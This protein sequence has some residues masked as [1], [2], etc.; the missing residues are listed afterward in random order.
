MTF[1]L[2]KLLENGG[3]WLE[4][5]QNSIL[6]AATIITVS[7][8]ISTIS[9]LLVTRILIATFFDTQAG[10]EALD[11]FWLAFQIP[12]M[13]FQLIILGALSA[14]FIP[15]FTSYKNK[16]QA[17]AFEM[18]SI[19][20]NILLLVFLLVG[21]LIFIFAGTLTH[22][23]TGANITPEQIRIIIN[24]TRLMIFAQ[25]F[26]AISNFMTGILQSF[27]RFIVPAVA[28]IFYNL[29]IIAGVLLFAD[30][31]G[32]YGAAL[33]VLLGAFL[34]MIIQLPLVFKLGFKYKFSFNLKF[35][36]VAE[37]FYLMPPRVFAIGAGEIRKLLLGFFATSLGNL[38]FTLMQ[39]TLSLM[40]IPIRFFGVPI[41]QA[42]L[43]FLAEQAKKDRVKFVSLIIQSLN[44]ITFLTLPAS[45][46][47]L[48]LRVP[49]VRFAFGTYNFPW[50]ATV[51]T[52]KLVAIV[53][54]SIAAQALVHLL[55][56]AFYAL[57]D[58]RTPLLIAIFDVFLY[59][60][61]SYLLVFVW[62]F[63][64][65]GIAVATSATALIELFLFLLFLQLKLK[66]FISEK[67]VIPQ[68]KMLTAGFLMGVFLYLPFKLLDE[69]IFNTSKTI[70]LLGLSVVT[71]TVGFLVYIYFA[72]LFNIHELKLLLRL[73]NNFKPWQ[74]TLSQTQEV[75]LETAVEAEE[76]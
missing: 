74:K 52:G 61:I 5:Q 27:Q 45:V 67:L 53:S 22:L 10:R 44:Q 16:D 11:A 14:A 35:D 40:A 48:I 18:S 19:M 46:L 55:N 60:L 33:G 34:H 65:L 13:M 75:V 63:G 36:G 25:F 20:M 30:R 59:L 15:I 71:G 31:F 41:G 8:A 24:L 73:V 26:F 64:V 4:K 28:P 2:P 49:V 51:L 12:D 3:S 38:S 47:L 68:L 62:K 39:L 17:K 6:S 69:L 70:E 54:V 32:V 72:L 58:T 76:L 29:G 66:N 37:F 56:R 42:S 21:V 7:T 9:G 50:T 57:K 43:P 1:K 23:R